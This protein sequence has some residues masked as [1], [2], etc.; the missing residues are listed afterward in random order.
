MDALRRQLA[1]DALRQPAQR[2]LRHRERGGELVAL[3]AGRGAGEQ[4]RPPTARQHPPRRLLRHQES[5]ERADLQRLLP[6][7]PG[8]ARPAAR[9]PGRW[10]CR[11]RCR[12]ARPAARPWW[13]TAPPPAPARPRRR[14]R[15][16]PRSPPPAHAACRHCA[17][18]ARPASLPPPTAAPATRSAHRRRRRSTPLCNSFIA[19]PSYSPRAAPSRRGSTPLTRPAGPIPIACSPLLSALTCTFCPRAAER[20]LEGRGLGAG[21]EL[22]RAVAAQHVAHRHRLLRAHAPVEHADQRL[23]DVADDLAA[24]RRADQ[25]AGRTG[26][27]EHDRRRHRAA[28]PLAGLDPVGDR[29][30]VDRRQRTRSRSARC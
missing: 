10:H 25:Q 20:R 26:G 13:R 1:G 3:D 8:R 15:S 16:R 28:R 19:A 18:R 2:E 6:R 30:A 11:S 12:A 7:P 27:I 14:P 24:A 9:A 22:G 29:P 4:D 5:A 23:R 21:L 17:R